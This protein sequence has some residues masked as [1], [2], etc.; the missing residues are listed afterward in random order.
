MSS[1]NMLHLELL[2]HWSG[3]L[4]KSFLMTQA[5]TKVYADV[6]M[7][8]GLQFP[9][10]MRQIL[11]TSALS[12]SL[13]KPEQRD[14][15][16]QHA[17][18]LQSE[19]LVGFNAAVPDLSEDNIVAAFLVSSLIGLHSFCETFSFRDGQ[20]NSTL[21]AFIGCIHLLRGIRSVIGGWWSFLLASEL[22]PV[23]SLAHGVRERSQTS[24]SQLSSLR[25]LIETADIGPNSKQA[26]EKTIEEL[27]QVY[28]SQ[29]EIP[30]P[31]TGASANMIFGWLVL[32]PREFVELV[33]QRRPEALIILAYYAVVLH[34]RKQFWAINDAGSFLMSGI[35]AHLGKHWE[36]WLEWPNL[37]IQSNID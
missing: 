32:V 9:F 12:L 8:H 2:Y 19:A 22:N 26:Y 28:A 11:A 35:R 6:C 31:E 15:Y 20:F 37:H 17:V 7:R 29:P 4:Y 24:A 5:D 13:W 3:G 18:Q 30:D 1:L 21:D 36:H 10:L 27:E 16:H 25:D 33:A 23:L 34:R 14:Y